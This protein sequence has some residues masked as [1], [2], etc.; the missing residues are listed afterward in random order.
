[1]DELKHRVSNPT[2]NQT[3]VILI[4]VAARAPGAVVGPEAKPAEN[5]WTKGQLFVDVHI[6]SANV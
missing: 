5:L 1:M 4:W 6:K 3:N 2:L